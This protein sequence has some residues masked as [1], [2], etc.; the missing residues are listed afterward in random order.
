MCLVNIAVAEQTSEKASEFSDKAIISSLNP[1]EKYSP[2]LLWITRIAPDQPQD[3]NA[4]KLTFI[5]NVLL[6]FSQENF[7]AHALFIPDGK[8]LSFV[9]TVQLR[10]FHLNHFGLK[11]RI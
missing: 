2:F 10:R 4:Q 1:A 8:S 7:K 5:S 9:T 3:F 6:L 11:I